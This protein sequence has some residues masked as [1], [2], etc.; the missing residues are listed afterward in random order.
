MKELIIELPEKFID[1]EDGFPYSFLTN[2]H[3]RIDLFY[4]CDGEDCIMP[5]ERDSIILPL[6]EPKGVWMVKYIDNGKMIL[7]DL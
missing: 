3:I 6:P 7:I 4:S 2:N 5:L 1:K